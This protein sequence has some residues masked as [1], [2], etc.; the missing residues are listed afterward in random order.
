[1]KEKILKILGSIR[2]WIITLALASSIL[3]AIGDGK[4]TFELITEY[5]RNYFLAVAAIGSLDK[6]AG[7]LGKK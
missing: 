1:M 4:L 5:L 6:V 7:L 2:F 3:T